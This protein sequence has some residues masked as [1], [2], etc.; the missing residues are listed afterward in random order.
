MRW[1]AAS[2]S[3]TSRRRSRS[4][5]LADAA[6]A[7]NHHPDLTIHWNTVTVRWWTHV[8][9]AITD[10]DVEMARRTDALAG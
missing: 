9:D 6:E 10:R 3:A 8:K 4:H 5:R 2:A 1:S 7:A